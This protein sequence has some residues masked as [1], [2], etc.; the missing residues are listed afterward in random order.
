M[1]RIERRKVPVLKS[2]ASAGSGRHQYCFIEC[3]FELNNQCLNIGQHQGSVG[4]SA[5]L[6]APTAAVS[7][8]DF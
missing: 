6:S 4:F 5:A 1:H 2:V 3:R 8:G 7:A